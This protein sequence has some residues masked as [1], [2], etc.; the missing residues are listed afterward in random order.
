VRPIGPTTL[1]PC[2]SDQPYDACCGLAHGGQPAATAQALMRSRYT[3]YTLGLIDYLVATTLPT[4]QTQLDVLAMNK[5]SQESHWLGLELEAV[6]KSKADR[7]QVTFTAHWADP[8]GT[9]HH[10]RERSDFLRHAGQWYFID[11]NHQPDI[12][13]NTPC[14]C[15]SGK[16]FKRC[17]AT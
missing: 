16:K 14:P 1:C 11:P 17:C 13:R 9:R 8:D 6:T 7:A 4:Q 2:G 15:G 12:S 10:R 3:A 5:W